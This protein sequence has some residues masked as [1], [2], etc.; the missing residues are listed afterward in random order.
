MTQD[1]DAGDILILIP[2]AGASSRMRGRDKLL[3]LIDGQP[4]LAR[5]TSRALDTGA[6]VLV[7]LAIDRPGRGETLADLAQDRLKMQAIDGREGMAVSIR[8]GAVEAQRSGA[9][10]LMIVLPDMPELEAQ[11]MGA[12]IAAQRATPDAALRAATEEGTPGHPV[13]F[14]RRLFHDLESVTGDAGARE[15]LQGEQVRLIPLRGKRAVTDLDTPEEWTRW[16][17]LF[18]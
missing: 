11:D 4:L 6:R 16:Q 2:A 8:A 10:A 3:E 12:L 18:R 13:V 7:T 14:P 15:V 5:Q 1:S 9:A 17:C